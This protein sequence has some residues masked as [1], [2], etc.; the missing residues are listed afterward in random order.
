V[1]RIALVSVLVLFA[2]AAAFEVL[3][4]L[5]AWPSVRMVR[6]RNVDLVAGFALA[7]VL[8]GAMIESLRRGRR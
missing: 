6:F 8:A 4:G 1:K 3:R 7:A 5:G 2:F